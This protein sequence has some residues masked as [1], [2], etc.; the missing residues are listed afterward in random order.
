MYSKAHAAVSAAVAVALVAAGYAFAHPAVVVGYAT[1]IGVLIDL[2]HFLWA[3]YNTG[4]WA[5]LRGVLADPVGTLLDQ[6]R[7]FA[8]TDLEALERL[9]SHVV[10]VGVAV[11]LTWWLD[12]AFGMVTAVT[13]YAHVLSDLVW[14][15]WH[16]D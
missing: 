16:L 5:A 9:L 4:D 7:I 3:R 10:V 12:P 15:V 1:A 14:D 11:P 2:D 8:E 6:S 13:L